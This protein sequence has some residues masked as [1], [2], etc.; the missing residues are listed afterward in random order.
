MLLSIQ[1]PERRNINTVVLMMTNGPTFINDACPCLKRG[2]CSGDWGRA[3]STAGYVSQAK[4]LTASHPKTCG[5]T[6]MTSFRQCSRTSGH[7]PLPS[8]PIH[9]TSA[10]VREKQALFNDFVFLCCYRPRR[11]R[12]RM[13]DSMEIAR[14]GELVARQLYRLR[15]HI[16][17]QTAKQVS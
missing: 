12:N 7:C 3:P 4:I 10:T 11:I 5:R 6:K 14:P 13:I 2:G 1:L 8:P 16:V 15:F 9:F 17:T